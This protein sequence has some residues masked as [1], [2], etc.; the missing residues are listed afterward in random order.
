MTTIT[1]LHPGAM[2]APLASWAVANGHTVLW[3][4]EGRSP[5]TRD[6]AAKAGLTERPDLAGALGESE[7]VL[8]VCPPHA[9][10]DVARSVAAHGYAGLYIEANAIS[11]ARLDAVS[12]LLGPSLVLDGAIIGP[13]PADGKEARLYLAGAEEH[14]ELAREIFDGNAVKVRDA[15]PRPGAASALKMAFGGYQKAARTL[16]AVAHALA[17]DH[18]VGNL[19]TEEAR[20]MPGAILADREYIP[21]VAARAWRWAP[22]MHEVAETLE[23]AHLPPHL[24]HAAAE[25]MRLWDADKDRSDLTPSEALAHLHDTPADPTPHTR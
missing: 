12:S 13:P 23:A 11:P 1:L 10:E 4:S 16:A 8:S 6:R 22:E 5:A 15:G 7:I 9:A 3:V 21:S 19:L 24:A 2:G 14:Q 20:T 17:D 25:T 18:G